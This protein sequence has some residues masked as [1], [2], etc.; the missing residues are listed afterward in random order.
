MCIR[1]KSM[2]DMCDPVFM[3]SGNVLSCTKY[4]NYLGVE[5]TSTMS[6]EDAIKIQRNK[7]YSRGNMIIS[8]F[9]NCSE[10]VKCRLFQ[11]F[12]STIYCSSI[13]SG[14]TVES[15]RLLKVAY[16]RIFRILMRLK[17]RSSMSANFVERRL[18]PFPVIIR[19]SIGSFR[20]RAYKSDNVLLKTILESVHFMFSNLNSRW[21]KAVCILS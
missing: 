13:W 16:N 4:Q 1:P 11:S 18:N 17:H 20:E 3:L 5:I 9:R 10:S 21:K 7:L 8:K 2:I 6:D 14:F 19:K 15:M 12:C